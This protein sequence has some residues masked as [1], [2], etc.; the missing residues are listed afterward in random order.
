MP[1]HSKVQQYHGVP[2]Y[3]ETVAYINKVIRDFYQ[4]AAFPHKAAGSYGDPFRRVKGSTA[5][6]RKTP[7]LIGDAEVAARHD[8]ERHPLSIN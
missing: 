2:P 1:V 5:A 6:R 8:F 7:A 3:K 4:T